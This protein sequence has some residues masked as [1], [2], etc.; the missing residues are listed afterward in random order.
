MELALE[1]RIKK[2]FKF[3]NIYFPVFYPRGIGGFQG[4]VIR[5]FIVRDLDR[6]RVTCVEHVADFDTK[7][8]VGRGARSSAVAI[9]ERMDP[10]EAP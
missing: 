10:I 2:L 1:V 8:E 6:N 5:G 4:F 7:Y 3:S 9:R